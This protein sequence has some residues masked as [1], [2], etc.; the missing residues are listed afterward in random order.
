MK[1]SNR[2]IIRINYLLTGIPII[3]FLKISENNGIKNTFT[4]YNFCIKR[5]FFVANTTVDL[6]EQQLDSLVI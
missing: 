3:F 6:L 5:Y 1:T 4:C 2:L